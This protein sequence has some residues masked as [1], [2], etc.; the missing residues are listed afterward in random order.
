MDAEKEVTS[1]FQSV[2]QNYFSRTFD[3]MSDSATVSWGTGKKTD[4]IIVH[5]V[6]DISSSYITQKM[7]N[8]K[9]NP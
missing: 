7:T 8:A 9:I 3:G 6:E 4:T 1:Q 2:L 5:F